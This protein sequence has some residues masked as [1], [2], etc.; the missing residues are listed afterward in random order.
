MNENNSHRMLQPTTLGSL[1]LRN[2]VM[3][4]AMENLLNNADG[5]ISQT[6]IDY[7]VARARGGVGVIVLQNTCVDAYASRSMY[8]QLMLH[9]GHMM[10]GLAR[11]AA[12]VHAE[13]AALL[14]QLGH[15]GRQ[16]NPDALPEGVQQVAPS[17]IAS[18]FY[19]VVPH[20]LTLEEIDQIQTAFARAA[21]RAQSAGADGVELHGAHGYLIHQF[22]SPLANQRSDHYGGSAENRT[23]FLSEIISRVREQ[24]GRDFVVGLRLD[25]DECLPGGIGIDD[26]IG[27]ARLVTASGQLDFL[28]VSAGVYESAPAMY[29]GMYGGRGVYTL[30]AKQF[31]EAMDGLP[32]VAVGGLDARTSE[33]A[34]QEGAADLVAIGRGLIADPE[35]VNKVADNR[36]QDI[37]PC[38]Q[39]NEA[40]LGNI[41][42][43]RPMSCAVNPACGREAEDALALAETPRSVLVIG[44]GIG[45][46]EAARVASLKG[47]RVTLL[48][49]GGRLGGHLNEASASPFK[50]QL[51]E[52]LA[53][54]TTQLETSSVNVRLNTEATSELVKQENPDSIIVAV[55]STWSSP[56][57][58]EGVVTGREILAGECELGE[59][60]VIVGAGANGAELALDISAMHEIVPTVVER[61]DETMVDMEMS[62]KAVL[63]DM[64]QKQGVVIHTGL[65]V[66]RVAG[67][68]V[69]CES[70]TGEQRSLPADTVVLCTGLS[71]NTALASSFRDLAPQV[72]CIGDCVS[73]RK[74]YQALH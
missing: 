32:I 30:L 33:L 44:G 37:C 26:A 41:I 66:T 64:L 43:G 28:S 42:L 58:G 15:G 62:H 21:G 60:V 31:R 36:V 68:R 34:L 39:C 10:P 23:R 61:L 18:G 65:T 19:G 67:G 70:A 2:R 25:G 8:S 40:C 22:L 12:A 38:I 53:W 16:S 63:D 54:A 45:G 73:P 52:L 55:G 27:Q 14:V 13:G 49:K 11:L 48:E 59:Q 9:N 69:D 56:F 5:S 74:I 71:P 50:T 47:H 29:P 72:Q 20:Q 46:M 6:L 35:L 17:P 24:V 3:M 51:G 57:D 4:P 7:Y 1:Q